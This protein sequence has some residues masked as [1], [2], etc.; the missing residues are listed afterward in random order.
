MSYLK[1]RVATDDRLL[2]LTRRCPECG[3]TMTSNGEMYIDKDKISWFV[4]FWC[5]V[6]KEVFPVWAPELEPAIRQ[7]AQGLDVDALPFY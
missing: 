2:G 3:A 1:R 5:P 7:A 4:G 6:D